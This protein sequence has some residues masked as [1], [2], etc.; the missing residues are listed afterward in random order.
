MKYHFNAELKEGD[1]V[2][3]RSKEFQTAAEL[4]NMAYQFANVLDEVS[5]N[6]YEITLY[7]NGYYECSTFTEK[8]GDFFANVCNIISQ[9]YYVCDVFVYMD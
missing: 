1:K 4:I 5:D 7:V 8:K 6:E 3:V 2:I 9:T